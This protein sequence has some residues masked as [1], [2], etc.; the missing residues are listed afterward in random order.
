MNRIEPSPR[1]DL[2][3]VAGGHLGSKPTASQILC[4]HPFPFSVKFP[5]AFTGSIGTSKTTATATADCD[6]RKNGAS[7]GTLRFSA[8]IAAPAFLVSAATSF[9]AGDYLEIIAPSS[10]DATLQDIAFILYGRR[11]R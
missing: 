5:A 2:Y 4:L 1:E 6:I 9:S 10:Q 11:R 7:I 3:L 8:G